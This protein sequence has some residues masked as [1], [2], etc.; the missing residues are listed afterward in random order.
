MLAATVLDLQRAQLRATGEA[1]TEETADA[2]RALAELAVDAEAAIAG[3]RKLYGSGEL[4]ESPIAAL[5]TLMREAATLLRDCAVERARLDELA[6]EVGEMVELLLGHVTAVEDIEANMRLVGLNAAVKCAQLGPRGASLSV[7]A[8]Q[9]RELTR[10]LV[11]A[12]QLAVTRLEEATRIAHAFRLSTSGHGATEVAE[13]ETAANEALALV[14]TVDTRLATAL[15]ALDRDGRESVDFLADASQGLLGHA[16][17]AEALADAEM[18]I[19]A[20]AGG[21]SGQPKDLAALAAPL[22]VIRKRY[23]TQAE[24]LLHDAR[25]A[26]AGLPDLPVT[27]ETGS[28][29]QAAAADE[30]AALDALLF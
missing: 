26:A 16:D 18:E 25:L 5:G 2:E 21:I 12:A 15:A 6:R 29:P 10:E 19:A 4:G 11:P 22:Q 14:G 13:L 8:A 24:R 23:S 1:F 7:I 20:L 17:I 3:C 27:A 9:L 30:D 28:S